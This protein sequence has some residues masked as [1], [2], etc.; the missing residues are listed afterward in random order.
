MFLQRACILRGLPLLITVKL[1]PTQMPAKHWLFSS[2]FSL[3]FNI[4][5]PLRSS[6]RYFFL[7]TRWLTFPF[8]SPS[9][10]GGNSVC[11]NLWL[12]GIKRGNVSPELLEGAGGNEGEE[13]RD[14]IEIKG[15]KEHVFL[16]RWWRSK[17][18]AV[19]APL[20]SSKSFPG[21]LFFLSNVPM[22]PLV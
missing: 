4:D 9:L 12:M 21:S 8:I 14:L 16:K 19:M 5:S 3:R 2:C 10:C 6:S 13:K 15:E 1:F 18:Q 22:F 7:V 17:H 20:W 11:D